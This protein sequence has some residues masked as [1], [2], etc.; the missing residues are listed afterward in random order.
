MSKLILF[1][2]NILLWGTSQT[3][4]FDIC[5][6]NRLLFGLISVNIMLLLGIDLL[7]L[8]SSEATS[9]SRSEGEV[10]V[11]LT[12]ATN[13]P[14]K[15]RENA[16]VCCNLLFHASSAYFYSFSIDFRKELV[17]DSTITVQCPKKLAT[18]I[19][20][21]ESGRNTCVGYSYWFWSSKLWLLIAIGIQL[22]MLS[23]AMS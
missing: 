18:N 16:I 2:F 20:W 8:R 11:L 4:L 22:V 21:G 1:L 3:R 19:S 14:F 7:R 23:S 6:M 5:V 13:Q 9:L 17:I 15:I 10:C 12:F